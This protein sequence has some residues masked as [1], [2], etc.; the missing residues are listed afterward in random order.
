MDLHAAQQRQVREHDDPHRAAEVPGVDADQELEKHDQREPSRCV[1]PA[2][3]TRRLAPTGQAQLLQQDDQRRAQ[4]QPRHDRLEQARPR[5]SQ[6]D[7]AQRRADRRRAAAATRPSALFPREIDDMPT[8]AASEPGVIATALVAFA[9]TAGMPDAIA[10][11]NESSVPP[12]AT[13]LIAPAATDEPT[14][15]ASR[16]RFMT[17][18]YYLPLC[19]V[20]S[21]ARFGA[22]TKIDRRHIDAAVG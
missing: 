2:A 11:G 8:P 7:C 13:E 4:D 10:A 18:R 19:Q 14:R 3:V 15:K 1:S 12:P 5:V 22:A 9:I 20:G 17:R 16:A 6:D 21:D